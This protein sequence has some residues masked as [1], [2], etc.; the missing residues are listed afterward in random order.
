MLWDVLI[1]FYFIQHFTFWT[2]LISGINIEIDCNSFERSPIQDMSG[3]LNWL[4]I[5]L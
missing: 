4:G 3:W 1:K 2:W 5:I